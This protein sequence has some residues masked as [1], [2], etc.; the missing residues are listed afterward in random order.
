M[1]ACALVQCVTLN[2]YLPYEIQFKHL[3]KSKHVSNEH[4][5]EVECIPVFSNVR[6][7]LLLKSMHVYTSNH[8]SCWMTVQC[9]H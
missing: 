8:F 1:F 5:V 6:T 2:Q 3:L 4:L 9:S 7:G